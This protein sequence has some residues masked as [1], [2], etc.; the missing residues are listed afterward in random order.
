MSINIGDKVYHPCSMDILEFK[1]VGIRKYE[2]HNTY[3]AESV[4]SVGQYSKIKVLLIDTDALRYIEM[5]HPTEEELG[6]SVGLSDFT[7]GIYYKTLDEARLKYHDAQL[8]LCWSSVNKWKQLHDEA[9]KNYDRNK[10]IID[11]LKLVIAEKN[12]KST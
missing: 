7:E 12:T 8:I 5:L 4:R 11:D 3:E 6:H 9:V 2:D 10:K 1:I